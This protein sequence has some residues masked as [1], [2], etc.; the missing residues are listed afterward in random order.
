MMV[1]DYVN[2]L[3]AGTHCRH[4]DCSVGDGGAC[5]GGGSSSDGG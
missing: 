5:H 4:L 2:L 3:V 1:K